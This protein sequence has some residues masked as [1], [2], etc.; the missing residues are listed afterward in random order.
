[1]H[2]N[3]LN[4]TLYWSLSRPLKYMGLTIDEWGVLLLGGI[5]GLIFLNSANA[6]LG[7]SFIIIGIILCYGFKKFKKLSEYFL[8]K[9]YLVA[10]GILPAPK[11]YPALLNKRIGK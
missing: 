5:P 4:Q 10:K 11:G 6:T 8:L 9:S 7:L 2:N 1:M 3:N